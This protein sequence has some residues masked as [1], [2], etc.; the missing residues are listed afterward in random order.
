MTVRRLLPFLAIA[1]LLFAP[2]CGG[3]DE[4]PL[5]D[6][7][8]FEPELQAKVHEIRDLTAEVRE[9][10]PGE[11]ISEGTLTRDALTAFYEEWEVQAREE[12]AS[13]IE[14][15]NIAY[16]LLHFIG[17]DDDLLDLFSGMYSSEAIGLYS[18]EEDKLVLVTE[19][20]PVLDLDAEFTL[21]HE[22]VHSF[23]YANFD[24]DQLDDMAEKEEEEEH[25]TE[26]STTISALMEGDAMLGS[27][28]YMNKKLGYWGFLDWLNSPGDD[29][30]DNDKSY[31]PAL[32]RYFYFPYCYGTEFVRYLWREGGWE[33]VNKAYS[34]P[35]NTT[36]QIIHPD[37]YLKGEKADALVLA[38]LTDALGDGWEEIY[39]GVF[40]EFDVYNYLLTAVGDEV[41]ASIAA[42]GWG[43]GRIAI[44]A[45]Q[46]EQDRA[47]IHLLIT[48]DTQDDASDFLASY[49][50]VL[51][52][53]CDGSRG[54]WEQ[55]SD[56]S[57]SS[58]WDGEGEHS[59]SSLQGNA[60]TM[61]VGTHRDDVL[62]AVAA[63]QPA[64]AEELPPEAIPAG[65]CP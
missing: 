41:M 48:W 18:S 9:L 28:G 16:R 47:L 36:E 65:H 46:K 53:L 10:E 5:P 37:K 14:A 57:W 49:H 8:P 2:G 56:G 38:D 22:Y 20:E 15:F 4:I 51:G 43:G 35:P 29:P 21:S 3:T 13:E 31:P 42:E 34:D 60:F 50:L 45:S 27:Y 12:E 61:L 54:L 7:T 39:D 6:L 23:Q 52:T 63:L 30:T 32:E 58:I 11:E 64:A 62:S 55:S 17:P 19:S 25:N 44:Y 1:V 40:G 26:Y 59:Y 33:K 24:I